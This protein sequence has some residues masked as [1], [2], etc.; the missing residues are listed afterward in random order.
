[1]FLLIARSGLRCWENQFSRVSGVKCGSSVSFLS[2]LMGGNSYHNE[3][4]LTHGLEQSSAKTPLTLGD[5][6]VPLKP[7]LDA[8]GFATQVHCR[9]TFPSPC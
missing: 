8:L 6:D 4:N 2:V 5:L 9:P 1:M 7:R 3:L